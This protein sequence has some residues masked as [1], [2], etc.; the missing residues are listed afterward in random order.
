MA[1]DKFYKLLLSK[2]LSLKRGT[3]R[4]PEMTKQGI[5][6]KHSK[7]IGLCHKHS[8]CSSSF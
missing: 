3:G 4:V 7:A 6:S 5:I 1:S 2:H 8:F